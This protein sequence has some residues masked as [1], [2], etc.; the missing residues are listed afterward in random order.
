MRKT[1]TWDDGEWIRTQAAEL[2]VSFDLLWDY[3]KKYEARFHATGPISALEVLLERTQNVLEDIQNNVAVGQTIG[4]KELNAILA[5]NGVTLTRDKNF[6]RKEVYNSP[7]VEY[8]RGANMSITR[9]I[10]NGNDTGNPSN[11][12]TSPTDE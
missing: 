5:D 4:Y 2:Q 3:S 7:L 1:I 9:R 8:N 11:G 10:T 6:V 12:S